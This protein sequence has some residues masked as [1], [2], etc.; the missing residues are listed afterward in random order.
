VVSLERN[1][2]N[3]TFNYRQIS[4]NVQ[5]EMSF[6]ISKAPMVRITWHDARDTETGWIPI[7]DI[8]S[9]PLAICQEVG[10]MVVNNHQKIV[11]MRSW[12]TDKD[13]NH[14]GGAIAIPKGW[15]TKIEY[16]QVAYSE[17]T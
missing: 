2:P 14:G 4:S 8:I 16:L 9:A 6:D 1:K 11:I 3:L 5:L 13:D 15:V 12:C 17:T 7:K 10:W